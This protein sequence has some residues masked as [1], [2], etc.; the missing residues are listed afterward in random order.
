ML[1][2]ARD[3]FN[4]VD[5]WVQANDSAV[6]TSTSTRNI[7]F[8]S[9]GFKIRATTNDFNASGGTIIYMAFAENP[10]VTSGAT[11]VTAR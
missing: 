7:D 11:P 4:T 1:D 3:E 9:N 10:F 8:L 5:L 2:S 6:E